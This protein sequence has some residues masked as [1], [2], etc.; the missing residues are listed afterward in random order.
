MKPNSLLVSS[1]SPCIST[2]DH[3]LVGHLLT[4]MVCRWVSEEVYHEAQVD[5]ID[6]HG[7]KLMN[8]RRF[9]PVGSK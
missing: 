1:N 2:L 5:T 9:Y 4:T 7:C 6:T 3:E 8:R